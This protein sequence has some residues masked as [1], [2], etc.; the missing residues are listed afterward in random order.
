MLTKIY[1]VATDVCRSVMGCFG[2]SLFGT[3]LVKSSTIAVVPEYPA[4]LFLKPPLVEEFGAVL[5]FR[6]GSKSIE[7]RLPP[8]DRIVPL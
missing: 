7:N 2:P 6:Y 3:T 4:V 8:I 5:M 1:E